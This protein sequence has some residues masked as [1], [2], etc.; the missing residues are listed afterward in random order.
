MEKYTK[1]KLSGKQK[2]R[3]I[4]GLV[5]LCLHPQGEERIAAYYHSAPDIVA[6]IDRR[7]NRREIFAAVYR[8]YIRP[9]V[10][11]AKRKNYAECDGIYTAMVNELAAQYGG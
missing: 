10:E 3:D 6:N 2:G 9:C 5:W 1:N 11:Q 7:E 8:D 4:Y